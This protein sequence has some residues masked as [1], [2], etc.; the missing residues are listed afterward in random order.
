MSYADIFVA[1]V[2]LHPHPA[3]DYVLSN[4]E[5][6]RV[7]KTIEALRETLKVAQ[8]HGARWWSLGDLL[9]VGSGASTYVQQAL[10]NLFDE[11][12]SVEKYLLVGN[13]ERPDRTTDKTALDFLAWQADNVTIIRGTWVL[14]VGDTSF[15][16]LPDCNNM[17]DAQRVVVDMAASWP[18]S[19][20]ILLGHGCV[21]GSKA[22]NGIQLTGKMTL[23]TLAA[24]QFQWCIFGDIHLPQVLGDNFYYVGCLHP[25]NYGER[26]LSGSYMALDEAGNLSWLATQAG[27]RFA[28]EETPN[29]ETHVVEQDGAVPT[30]SQSSPTAKATQQVGGAAPRGIDMTNLGTM[31]R[32][33]MDANPPEGVSVDEVLSELGDL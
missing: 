18:A 25:Q 2:H 1:D 29:V 26:N 10:L 5:S 20:K 19:K 8:D 21:H 32:A 31:V 3:G 4:G 14:S 17:A 7:T 30:L 22:A 11:F 6:F 9:H 28:Y 12:P 24:A 23:D 16:C 27:L 33:Y 13:H 15:F